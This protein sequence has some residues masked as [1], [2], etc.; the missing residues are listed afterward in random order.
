MI[1]SCFDGDDYE[2]SINRA[3]NYLHLDLSLIHIYQVLEIVAQIQNFGFI[4]PVQ[5]PDIQ[6]PARPR[7]G[8]GQL[9]GL[10][11]IHI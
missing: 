5:E 3:A 6:H 8:A 9:G 11:L 2:S 10:S 7:G 1:L 4:A